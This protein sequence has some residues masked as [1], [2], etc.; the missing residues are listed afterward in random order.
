MK[1]IEV[2][3][4]HAGMHLVNKAGQIS[5]CGKNDHWLYRVAWSGGSKDICRN[6]IRALTKKA[7]AQQ[8]EALSK[9]NEYRIVYEEKEWSVVSRRFVQTNLRSRPSKV[10]IIDLKRKS[11]SGSRRSIDILLLPIS[12]RRAIRKRFPVVEKANK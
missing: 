7:I 1:Q 11:S 10:E 4:S 12:V 2:V 8:K 3:S 9:R 6:C 5:Y